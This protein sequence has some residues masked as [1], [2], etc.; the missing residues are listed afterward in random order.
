MRMVWVLVDE[1]S[2]AS[3]QLRWQ[4]LLLALETI[5]DLLQLT[6]QGFDRPKRNKEQVLSHL[7]RRYIVS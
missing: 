5:K 4:L 3:G 1:S 6:A 2:A 7:A